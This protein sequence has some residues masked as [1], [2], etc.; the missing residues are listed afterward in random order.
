MFGTNSL[1]IRAVP[2]IGTGRPVTA[3]HAIAR[4]PA[5]VTDTVIDR[6]D[7][8]ARTRL[9]VSRWRIVWRVQPDGRTVIEVC[10]ETGELTGL[11]VGTR[12]PIVSADAGWRGVTR[13]GDGGRRCWAL[14]IGH[15]PAG[16]GRPAVTFTRGRAGSRRARRATVRPD[17]MGGL[18][19]AAVLGRYTTVRCQL[20]TPVPARLTS[21]PCACPLASVTAW[22]TRW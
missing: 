15:A 13:G 18:W 7:A 19:V 22:H 4:A 11:I 1:A 9:A 12:L 2:G 8:G 10:D 14:A 3:P 21:A 17:I 5:P 20:T 6:S 16:V